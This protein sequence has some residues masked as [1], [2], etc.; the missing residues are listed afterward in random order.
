MTG[1]ARISRQHHPPKLLASPPIPPTPL[2]QPTITPTTIPQLPTA[3]TISYASA[4]STNTSGGCST[5][6]SSQ[7]P[8]SLPTKRKPSVGS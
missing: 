2:Q 5:V 3:K 8:N 1:Y 6:S 7:T 4:H